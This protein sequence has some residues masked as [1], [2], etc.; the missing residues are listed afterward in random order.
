MT[1]KSSNSSL[2]SELKMGVIQGRT[3]FLSV[4]DCSLT[5]EYSDEDKTVLYR[6]LQR[7]FKLTGKED[8]FSL[9][10]SDG[11]SIPVNLNFKLYII[12]HKPIKH[13]L[14][15]NGP[16]CLSSFYDFLGLRH[17]NLDVSVIDVELKKE[18]LESYLQRFV[19]THEKPEYQIRYKALLTDKSLHEQA[20]ENSQ[21]MVLNSVIDLQNKSLLSANN[22]LGIIKE[23]KESKLMALENIC[24]TKRSIE[25]LDK[26]AAA[27]R[28]LSHYA[29]V[30]LNSVQRLSLVIRYFNF[31][32]EKLEGILSTLMF[33]FQENK[34]ADHATCTNARV[35]HLKHQLLLNVYSHLQV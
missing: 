33:K 13:I 27:Y 8:E 29:C 9:T 34:I 30:V 21:N 14:G 4:D 7:D 25:V 35:L 24:E 2:V 1:L 20:L 23:S 17:T 31:S 6:V 16:V 5:K 15:S 18:T 12:V 32:I 28:Q 26:Q 10:L 19:M 22:L 3:V 11:S